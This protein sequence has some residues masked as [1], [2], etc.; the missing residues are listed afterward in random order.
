M[1]RDQII[2]ESIGRRSGRID[3]EREKEGERAVRGEKERREF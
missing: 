3:D 1:A 2:F